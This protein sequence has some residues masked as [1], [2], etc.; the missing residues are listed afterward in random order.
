MARI[1]GGER[2]LPRLH[3]AAHFVRKATGVQDSVVLGDGFVELFP[4]AIVTVDKIVTDD[5]DR[6]GLQPT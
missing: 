5:V 1:D 6:Y 3:K 2:A 4:D